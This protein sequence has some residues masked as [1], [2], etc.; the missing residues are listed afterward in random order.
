V[1]LPARVAGATLGIF[2]MLGLLLA[3]IGVYGVMSHS[4]SQRQREIGIR[5]AV[6]AARSAVVRLLLREGMAL[7]LV[8]S[9]IGLALAIAGAQL[10]RGVLIDGRGFDPVTFAL[11]PLVLGAVAFLAIWVPARRASSVN[12]VVVLRQ[13]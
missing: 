13:D 3:S 7:V 2:G 6:G 12:P 4:V 10:L 8:G 1:L 5:V 9:A 11:V